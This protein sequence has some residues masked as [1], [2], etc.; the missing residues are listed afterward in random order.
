MLTITTGATADRFHS[1]GR[2]CEVEYKEEVARELVLER[3]KRKWHGSLCHK[4]DCSGRRW[5]RSLCWF[6]RLCMLVTECTW[7][8]Q[9]DDISLNSSLI[10]HIIAI[11]QLLELVYILVCFRP[12]SVDRLMLFAKD[13][14]Y[15]PVILTRLYISYMREMQ[16]RVIAWMNCSPDMMLVNRQ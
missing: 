16:I 1:V 8:T 9:S 14:V 5:H 3:L 13:E 4:D 15:R 2:R 6:Q 11:L 10:I 12:R 7:G